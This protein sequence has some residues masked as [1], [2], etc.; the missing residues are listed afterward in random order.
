MYGKQCRAWSDAVSDLGLHCLQMLFC[1][2]TQGYYGIMGKTL[3][4]FLS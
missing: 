3:K 4:I 1:P 2:N